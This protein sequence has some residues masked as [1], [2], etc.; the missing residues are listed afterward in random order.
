MRVAELTTITA[1]DRAALEA[2][3]ANL[4]AFLAPDATSREV[5]TERAAT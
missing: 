4:V 1:A 3:A 2:E 5:R